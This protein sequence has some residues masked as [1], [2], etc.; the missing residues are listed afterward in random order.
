MEI[1]ALQSN[2]KA[3]SIPFEQLA[4]NPNVSKEDKVKEA[5]RQFEAILLRQILGEA[6]KTVI[7]SSENKDSNEKDIYNDMVDNQ[8]ADS[9]SRSGTFG[10]AKSLEKQ[11]VHQVLPKATAPAAKPGG[12]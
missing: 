2:V 9:I 6:R 3:S 12:H 1:P 11:L 4:A 7:T 5:C 10:L 8:M